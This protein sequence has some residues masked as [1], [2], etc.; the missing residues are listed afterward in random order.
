MRNKNYI[1][2][3]IM[4][5]YFSFFISHL[6]SRRGFTLVELLASIIVLVAVG[7]VIAG[8]ITSS[9]RGTNKT[10]TIENIRQSGNYALAQMSK[11][12]EY[13]RV[14]NGFSNDGINYVTNCPFSAPT[15]PAQPQAV[16]TN[17]NYIKV[18]P[19]SNNP[20]TYNCTS[21]PV[22]A[23]SANSD[24][25]IDANVVSL[26][27]CILVCVQTESTDAPIIKIGFTLGPKNSNNLLE[28]STPPISF[29]TSVTMRN[30]KR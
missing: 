7:S 28:N 13:A 4:K 24:P 5:K 2:F 9:L 21:S 14:F 29:E 15:P 19:L 18:T 17:Y 8:I 25:L 20:I 30:Y 10:T 3:K 1:N 11:N 6:S 27:S 12:I 26:I 16:R 22:A 23:I